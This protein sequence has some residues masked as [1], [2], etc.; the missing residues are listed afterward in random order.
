M[1]ELEE[2]ELEAGGTEGRALAPRAEEEIEEMT[3][4]EAG[5]AAV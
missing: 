5:I 3:A 2:A 4:S 1:R